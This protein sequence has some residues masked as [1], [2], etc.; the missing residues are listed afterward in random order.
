M[1][2]TLFILKISPQI[3][4]KRS[5]PNQNTNSEADQQIFIFTVSNTR[6]TI[7]YFVFLIYALGN[8]ACISLYKAI[9]QKKAKFSFITIVVILAGK[10]L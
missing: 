1:G 10:C 2:Y 4:N 6:C 8:E 5:N 3:R 7:F 9:E